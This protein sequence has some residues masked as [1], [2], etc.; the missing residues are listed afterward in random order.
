[1]NVINHYNVKN[2]LL[3]VDEQY[4]IFVPKWEY[5]KG[6]EQL[7]QYIDVDDIKEDMIFTKS[8][9]VDAPVSKRNIDRYHKR[10]FFIS[11]DTNQEYVVTGYMREQ[12]DIYQM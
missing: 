3:T 7:L 4:I 5:T 2:A 10:K 6:K 12:G 8:F 1:M 11:G 9:G